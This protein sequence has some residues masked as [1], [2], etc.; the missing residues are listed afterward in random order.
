M[1][2]CWGRCNIWTISLRSTKSRNQSVYTNVAW[3]FQHSYLEALWKKVL[4]IPSVGKMWLFKSKIET[5][6]FFKLPPGNSCLILINSYSPGP[7]T[8][9]LTGTYWVCS[10]G[11]GPLGIS[12]DLGKQLLG[13]YLINILLPLLLLVPGRLCCG[14]PHPS[15]GLL[16][17]VPLPPIFGTC[18][19]RVLCRHRAAPRGLDLPNTLWPLMHSPPR[20]PPGYSSL[21]SSASLFRQEIIKCHHVCQWQ[22]KKVGAFGS[23]P[24]PAISAFLAMAELQFGPRKCTADSKRVQKWGNVFTSVRKCSSAGEHVLGLCI[25]KTRTEKWCLTAPLPCSPQYP[26]GTGSYFLPFPLC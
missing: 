6:L 21:F 2:F 18:C 13:Q 17:L 15:P 24:V 4:K 9:I 3:T 10:R 23:A 22:G 19:N 1:W 14:P 8:Q 20:H 16:Q 25:Y 12:H 11:S 5:Y 26:K 7:V